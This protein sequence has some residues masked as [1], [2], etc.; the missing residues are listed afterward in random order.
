MKINNRQQLLLILTISIAGFF[1]AD[2]VIYT[3]LTDTWKARQKKIRKLR[4]DVING[5][6]LIAQQ[7][8]IRGDWDRMRTNS[9]P[10]ND[11]QAHEQILKS[12]RDWEQESGVVINGE[13]PQ[14]KEGDESYRTLV[15]RV[16]VSGNLWQ[17]DRFLYDLEKGP[18]GLRLESMNFITRDSSGRALGLDLQLS[19]LVL[20]SQA[21]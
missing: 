13:Q 11:L 10:N 6:N 19:G 15:C 16:D 18:S 5:K 1:V 4:A 12:L 20:T 14:W 21:Q 7:D 17:L 3:P 8:D 9:L 2:K